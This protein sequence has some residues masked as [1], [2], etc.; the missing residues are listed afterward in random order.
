MPEAETSF[1]A[2]QQAPPGVPSSETSVKRGQR[3]VGVDAE[4]MESSDAMI[5]A[6]AALAAAFRRCCG[7][8]G[9][10]DD[11]QGHYYTRD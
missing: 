1:R 4:L 9:C 10:F 8:S 11:A 2:D 7:T 6:H 3:V 5:T